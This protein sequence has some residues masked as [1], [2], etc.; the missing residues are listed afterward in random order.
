[1][2]MATVIWKAILSTAIGF[3]I[4][5][6]TN[7]GGGKLAFADENAGHGVAERADESGHEVAERLREV[8]QHAENGGRD[9]E[10][11][12]ARDAADRAERGTPDRAR[13]S[14]RDFSRGG[15]GR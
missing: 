2:N 3:L 13:D 11:R 4:A 5:G 12:D 10:A 8:S 7:T 15:A 6:G 14:D 1:M 9:R